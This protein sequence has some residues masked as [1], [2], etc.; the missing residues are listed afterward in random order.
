MTD[1]DNQ[2][3]DRDF[4]PFENGNHTQVDHSE[5]FF[6]DFTASEAQEIEQ[7][8]VEAEHDDFGNIDSA[9]ISD[10]AGAGPQASEATFSEDDFGAFES[11][12][13]NA[14]KDGAIS[15]DSSPSEVKDD[16]NK[17]NL[18]NDVFGSF[19]SAPEQRLSEIVSSPEK[20]DN[21][22]E[23]EDVFGS[24]D[25]A[26]EQGLSE[27]VNSSASEKSAHSKKEP[28]AISASNEGSPEDEEFGDFGDFDSAPT[29][30][31]E[32]AATITESVDNK[33][34]ANVNSSA[35]EEKAGLNMES[36]AVTESNE[37]NPGDEEFGDFGDFDSAPATTDEPAATTTEPAK[38]NENMN[39]SVTEEA[40]DSKTELAVAAASKEDNPEDDDFGDFGDFDSAPSTTAEAAAMALESA[41][42]NENVK[43]SVTEEKADSNTG[44]AVG[45]ASNQSNPEDD[46]FGDFGDFDSAP[47]T[48]A[49][50]A[51]VTLES[52]NNEA[53]ATE[54][55][56]DF[57]DF[58]SFNEQAPALAPVPAPVP[59]SGFSADFGSTKQTSA[60]SEED[61]PV[62][63]K[64]KTV[65][66]KV[67][68]QFVL[69]ES[70][71]DNDSPRDSVSIG[72]LMVSDCCSSFLFAQG[73][74]D[75]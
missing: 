5:D 47:S 25:S 15:V 55:A 7:S 59:A 66:S 52:D 57:G 61:N 53:N 23:G 2:L 49:E 56:D 63:Q 31:A 34:N 32:A 38:A 28:A 64:A 16:K 37:D 14:E 33:A 3:G 46:E 70:Q 62:L 22:N 10:E 26:P 19:D 8:T 69:E 58:S 39:S 29:T 43:S 4:K 12:N 45:M 72:S 65:F 44:S 48:T 50:A 42:A 40:A 18:D 41:E 9:P 30:T 71:D 60:S 73:C 20:E 36:S 24:F 67:F 68:Q 27:N 35:T 54:P 21:K 13:N 51:A 11:T 17:N 75:F 1:N 6:G 74:R